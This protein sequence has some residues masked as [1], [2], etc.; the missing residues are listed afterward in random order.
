MGGVHLKWPETHIF[1]LL[2]LPV[3]YVQFYQFTIGTQ[4]EGRLLCT[5]HYP[6]I[7]VV[8]ATSL[9][10]LYSLVSKIS[11]DW[12]SSMSI[13]RSHRTQG[14]SLRPSPRLLRRGGGGGGELRL[15]GKDKLPKAL[16]R[17]RGGERR[18]LPSLPFFLS[19]VW[20]SHTLPR[21]KYTP[22]VEL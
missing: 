11:P 1:S 13:I 8:D 14:Q 10:V 15:Y 7:L 18:D 9:E 2:S 16:L 3:S 4:R 6:E 22:S 19:H 20:S 21:G 5:G 12:I 17:A